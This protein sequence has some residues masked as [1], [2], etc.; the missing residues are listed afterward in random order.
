MPFAF[1][2]RGN[3][4]FVTS[5]QRYRFTESEGARL[6]CRAFRIGGASALFSQGVSPEHIKAI[7][8]WWSGAYL[9][10]IRQMQGNAQELMVRACSQPCRYMDATPDDNDPEDQE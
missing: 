7:G 3:H 5:I 8:R 6:L 10:Y 2:Y 9:L 4:P 1:T